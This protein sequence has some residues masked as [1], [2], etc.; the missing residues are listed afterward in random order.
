MKTNYQI[1][2]QQ[3]KRGNGYGQYIITGIVDGVEVKTITTDSEA[4]DWFNDDS[5]EEKHEE[6]VNHVNMKLEI[7]FENM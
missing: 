1:T 7:A 4:F 2:E 5:N 3:I 6:A